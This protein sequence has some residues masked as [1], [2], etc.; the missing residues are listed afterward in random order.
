M[1][2]RKSADFWRVIDGDPR[3]CIAWHCAFA[4][5]VD[6]GHI[7]GPSIGGDNVAVYVERANRMKAATQ[8]ALA[9]VLILRML[10]AAGS[11]HATY[12]VRDCYYSYYM[13]P[14]LQLGL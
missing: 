8:L 6:R 9:K 11:S 7:A 2:T 12:A 3:K 10:T 13:P 4:T 1:L 5:R 14:P